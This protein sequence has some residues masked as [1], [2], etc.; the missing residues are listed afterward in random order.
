MVGEC[1]LL[2]LRGS[3]VASIL[4]GIENRIID[5][6]E[7]AYLAHGKGSTLLPHSAFLRLPDNSNNRI[8]ALPGYVGDSFGLAG[9][10]WIASFPGNLSA[11]LDRASAV[12]VLNSVENGR[13]LCL[14]EGSIISATRTAA[15]ATLAARTLSSGRTHA[16]VGLVGC[17]VI[18]RE[19]IRFLAATDRTIE[20]VHVFD[21]DRGRA[22]AFLKNMPALVGGGEMH[23]APSAAA[24]LE[25][26]SLISF[27]TTA[28][29]PYVMDLSAC[30]AGT[31]ILHVSLRDIAP[32][33]LLACDNVTDDID[34][35]CREQTSLHLA[36]G[37]VGHRRFIRC[38]LP[39]ILSGIAE[40]T[41]V[42]DMPVVFSPF[43]LGVLD[44][45]LA[46]EVYDVAIR[47]RTG[48]VVPAF[49]PVSASAVQRTR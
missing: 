5:V 40:P 9:V 41:S 27:A 15:S 19:I 25:R 35:V 21:I 45:A 48:A 44:I 20:C 2:V 8:I 11:G 36:E 13:P 24:V 49:L 37:M 7:R 16:S 22:L 30:A 34:H 31:I 23:V 33:C 42:C 3:D 32:E 4:S 39:D 47:R 38:G 17:G 28:A 43:G 12:I 10:K 26:C 29:Q 18:N 46:K 6:V 14:L 1:D